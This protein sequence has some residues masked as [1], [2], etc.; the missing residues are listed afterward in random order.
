[1][2]DVLF[3]VAQKHRERVGDRRILATS[4]HSQHSCCID[5]RAANIT[6]D[7]PS[8]N[9]PLVDRCREELKPNEWWYVSNDIVKHLN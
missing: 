8:T 1:M 4:L 5:A 9:N 2:L 7:F 6:D 3:T